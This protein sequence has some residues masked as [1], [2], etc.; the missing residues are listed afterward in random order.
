MKFKHIN[1]CWKYL[2]ESKTLDELNDRIDEMPRWSG[3]WLVVYVGTKGVE[4]YEYDEYL[5]T[6]IVDD[7]NEDK[8]TIYFSSLTGEQI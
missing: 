4:P 3:S 1:E 8:E 5:I 2:T 6:N 7:M